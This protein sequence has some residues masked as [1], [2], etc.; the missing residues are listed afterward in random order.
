MRGKITCF[1]PEKTIKYSISTRKSVWVPAKTFFFVF[2]GDHLLLAGKT[3]KFSVSARKSLWISAKTFFFFGDQLI[4]TNK[5]PLSY[6]RIMKIWV[7]FVYGST[8]QKSLLLC[9]ILATR[10]FFTEVQSTLKKR[11]PMQNFTI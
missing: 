6:S 3:P 4:F 5:T 11:L 8:F 1:W 2:F 7:K 9:E 10:L